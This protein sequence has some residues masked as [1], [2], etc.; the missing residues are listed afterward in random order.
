[1]VVLPVP[2]ARAVPLAGS[3]STGFGVGPLPRYLKYQWAS[4]QKPATSGANFDIPVERVAEVLDDMGV[5]VDDRRPSCANWL[6]L[7]LEGLAP[8]ARREVE[9]WRRALHDGG[10]RASARDRATAWKY[11]NAVRPTS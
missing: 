11:L 9:A 1:M 7:E 10:P 8:G 6:D 2:D 4:A 3:G 5:L